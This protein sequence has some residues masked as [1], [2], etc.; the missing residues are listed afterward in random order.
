MVLPSPTI[1]RPPSNKTASDIGA[2]GSFG[3]SGGTGA[4]CG[5]QAPSQGRQRSTNLIIF[6]FPS[7]EYLYDAVMQRSKYL[8]A[9]HSV[10]NEPVG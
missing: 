1:S 5:V 6:I 2:G 4:S 9:F 7:S 3:C 8:L 10:A